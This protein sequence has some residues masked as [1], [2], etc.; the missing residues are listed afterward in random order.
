MMWVR[1]VHRLRRAL[2]YANKFMDND[3]ELRVYCSRWD[4]KNNQMDYVV[5]RR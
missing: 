1:L 4:C 5:S 2:A 3:R